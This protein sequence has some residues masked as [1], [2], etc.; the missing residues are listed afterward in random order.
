MI[1]KTRTIKYIFVRDNRKYRCRSN[2][3]KRV[4]TLIIRFLSDLIPSTGKL[5]VWRLRREL[6]EASSGGLHNAGEDVCLQYAYNADLKQRRLSNKPTKSHKR[7]IL[8]SVS[9]YHQIFLTLIICVFLAPCLC[10]FVIS[11][12]IY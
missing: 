6:K 2:K 7:I 3:H 5:S 4:N 9:A 11:V 10:K 12:Y 8:Q 1:Y